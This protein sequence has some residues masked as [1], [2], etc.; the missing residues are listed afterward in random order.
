[1]DK[2]SNEI[3]ELSIHLDQI[4]TI[5]DN[6]VGEIYI[7]HNII[8]KKSYV[9]QTVS[10]RKNHTKWR[11]FGIKGRFNDHISEALNNT[12]RKQCWLLNNS[13]RKH[14]KD[15]FTVEL[16]VRCSMDELNNLEIHYIKEYNTTY[17]NGYNLTS[18]GKT[19][20]FI[21][22]DKE[23]ELFDESPPKIKNTKRSEST[24]QLISSRLSDLYK[25][26]DAA[27]TK[28]MINAQ[29]QHMQKKLDTFK[30]ATIDVNNLE[31]YLRVVDSAQ[32]GKF[33]RVVI[34]GKRT[35]FIGKHQTLEELEDRAFTFLNLL[36]D[37]SMQHFQIAGTPLE[38]L[39]PPV[40]GNNN[41]GTQL[42][43]GSNGNNASGL[44]NPQP[45]S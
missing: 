35:S 4:L 19:L 21:K 14:G 23:F 3:D 1:M 7:I 12:K 20:K 45:S 16:L 2:L 31:Q 43:A 29:T 17:P 6:V 27:K 38:P 32:F 26:N 15:N 34:D 8:T 36:V 18:G 39:L 10:H 42:I 11:P 37:K 22:A 5:S 40:I 44:G 25:N 30:N 13:I 41:Q 28:M 9:G 33:Y 24:K